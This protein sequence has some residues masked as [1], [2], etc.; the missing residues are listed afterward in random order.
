MLEEP[1]AERALDTLERHPIAFTMGFRFLY[2]L[3][4]VSPV[5]FG[6]PGVRQLQLLAPN[7]ITAALWAACFTAIGFGLGGHSNAVFM[8]PIVRAAIR[9]RTVDT[10]DRPFF[11]RSFAS[12][13]KP[14]FHPGQEAGPPP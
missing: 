7:A 13:L 10:R 6:T 11:R 14:S 8:V 1:A 2:G 12:D 9:S 3:D 5:A 4:T